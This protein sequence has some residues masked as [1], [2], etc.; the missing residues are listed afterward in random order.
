VLELEDTIRATRQELTDRT[1]ET[2]D[3][4]N[5]IRQTKSEMQAILK[6]QTELNKKMEETNMK[7]FE[8]VDSS[9]ALS[10]HKLSEVNRS[11]AQ[12]RQEVQVSILSYVFDEFKDNLEELAQIHKDSSTQI[13][14]DFEKAITSLNSDTKVIFK[15]V[16]F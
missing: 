4:S 2:H 5:I 6:I 12:L 1:A 13:I 3:H 8:K 11:I 7:V 10:E 9:R 15:K 16:K 14:L